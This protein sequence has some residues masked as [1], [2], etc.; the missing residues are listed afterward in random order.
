MPPIPRR[1]GARVLTVGACA[2]ASTLTLLVTTATP[3]AADTGRVYALG[4][5]AELGSPATG[6]ALV[7]I[8]PIPTGTGYWTASSTG[9]VRPFGDAPDLGSSTRAGV[10][11][12][13]ATHTGRGYWL[14]FADGDVKAFGNAAHAGSMRG[15]ALNSPIV[16]ITAT[17]SG[18]GY[19][20]VAADGGIFSFGDAR[21][22]GSMGGS[23]LNSPITGIAATPTGKGYWMVAEDGGVFS[24]GDAP[25]RGSVST[26]GVTAIAASPR[27]FGYWIVGGNGDIHRF[28]DAPEIGDV[29]TAATVVDLAPRPQRDGY[30]LATGA[31][32]A[33]QAST[34]RAAAGDPPDSDFDRLAQC[35]SSGNW[36]SRGGNYEDGLQFMNST[37]LGYGGGEFARH[38][39]DATREQQIEIG[40]RLWRDKGWSPWPHCSRAVG[41]R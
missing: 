30:W 10:V 20:L 5:A 32:H 28:G 33:A 1:L 26:G 41:L 39:Y 6:E 31:L 13:A 4:K 12:I 36:A 38:A 11:D 18:G 16:G 22:L 14:T 21:Y 3:A 29:T 40:R 2:V 24:F 37:W 35:E 7:G 23:R 9:A 27:G 15:K 34:Y 17:P 8:A 19:W 25:F